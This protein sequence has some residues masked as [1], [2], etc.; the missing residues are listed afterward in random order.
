MAEGTQFVAPRVPE[1]DAP[2]AE[3]HCGDAVS[4]K[5]IRQEK[6]RVD[7]GWTQGGFRPPQPQ[8]SVQVSVQVSALGSSRSPQVSVPGA[9]GATKNAPQQMTARAVKLSL[10]EAPSAIGDPLDQK[11]PGVWPPFLESM[12]AELCVKQQ[13]RVESCFLELVG[14]GGCGQREHRTTHFH[15]SAVRV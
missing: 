11:I 6:H 7:S 9:P 2:P 13:Y 5:V 4:D 12:S 3:Q 10:G 1:P 14:T 8:V 15:S